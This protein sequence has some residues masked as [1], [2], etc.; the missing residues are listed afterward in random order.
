VSRSGTGWFGVRRLAVVGVAVVLL[1][2]ASGCSSDAMPGGG[3]SQAG[4]TPGE[5]LANLN[6]ANA[7]HDAGKWCAQLTD[8]H[9]ARWAE[10]M[11]QVAGESGSCTDAMR[12]GFEDLEQRRIEGDSDTAG[13]LFHLKVIRTAIDGDVATVR[14]S[15]TTGHAGKTALVTLRRS[16]G[17][18]YIDELG[19][20]GP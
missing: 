9:Q 5:T 19:D 14:V 7:D 11:E 2:G 3:G 13:R 18:W 4:K 8:G 15:D 6:E 20:F 12:M 10:A 16:G 1:A 17:R